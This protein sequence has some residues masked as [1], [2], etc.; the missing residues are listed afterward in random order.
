MTGRRGTM[1]MAGEVKKGGQVM[2]LRD[3]A[4]GKPLWATGKKPPTAP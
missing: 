1:L 4:T 2:K 3:E